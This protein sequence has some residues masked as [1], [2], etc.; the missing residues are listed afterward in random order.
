MLSEFIAVYSMIWR[1]KC[2]AY[3]APKLCRNR[4]AARQC[5]RQGGRSRRA[6]CIVIARIQGLFFGGRARIIASTEWL[7][8]G[9]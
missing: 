3:M 9:I 7:G 5:S 1:R 2:P 4:A 6:G 8:Q